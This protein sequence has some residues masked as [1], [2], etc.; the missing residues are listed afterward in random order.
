MAIMID[1][2]N[3]RFYVISN[4]DTRYKQVIQTYSD[5][6]SRYRHV[7]AELIGELYAA[8][9]NLRELRARIDL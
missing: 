4:D 8:E 9:L 2:S 1:Y 7:L 5:Y 6:A 3:V